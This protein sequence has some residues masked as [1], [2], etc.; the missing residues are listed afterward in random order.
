MHLHQSSSWKLQRVYMHV[1]VLCGRVKN[2]LSTIRVPLMSFHHVVNHPC[3]HGSWLPQGLFLRPGVT[4]LQKGSLSLSGEVWHSALL[5][6]SALLQHYLN[7]FFFFQSLSSPS[8]WTT[9]KISVDLQRFYSVWGK[10]LWT[11]YSIVFFPYKLYII[12]EL[13]SVWY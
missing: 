5:N 6:I 3:Q 10:L 7:S 13:L 4:D 12:I 2:S 8:C 1:S 9:V 11:H